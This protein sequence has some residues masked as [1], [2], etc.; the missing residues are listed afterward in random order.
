MGVGGGGGSPRALSRRFKRLLGLLLFHLAWLSGLQ[1]LQL[2]LHLRQLCTLRCDHPLELA[3]QAA[4]RLHR[5]RHLHNAA[6]C[7]TRGQPGVVGA[8]LGRDEL[9]PLED[10]LARIATALQQ[11]PHQGLELH[12]HSAHL[13]RLG[14]GRWAVGGGEGGGGEGGGGEGGGVRVVVVSVVAR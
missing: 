11:A 6:V 12:A 3:D 8:E 5:L 4:K 9:A 14:M 13:A 10:C 1:L 7:G 2:P